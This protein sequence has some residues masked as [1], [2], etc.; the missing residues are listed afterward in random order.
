M[1][2]STTFGLLVCAALLALLVAP[3]LSR[4]QAASQQISLTV[5]EFQ[6]SPNTITVTQ[7]QPV[8]FTVNNTGKFP[9]SISFEKNGKFLTVFA[10]PIAAGQT[11]EA[12][13][14]FEE[15]GNWVMFCPVA[16]HAENGMTGQALVLAAGSTPGMPSTG[17]PE[18]QI[19]LFAAIAALALLA[20]GFVVRRRWA[21]REV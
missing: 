2:R 6:I 14:T 16:T 19:T 10:K 7:G 8:H 4:A 9:H 11:G 20:G 5:S 12:D 3:G 1:K 17:Q 21:E 15:S 18:D 13:F